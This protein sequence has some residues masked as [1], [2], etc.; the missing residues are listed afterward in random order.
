[1]STGYVYHGALF[2]YCKLSL[3]GLST[4]LTLQT[5]LESPN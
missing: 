2:L 3:L 1:M 5:V 4:P